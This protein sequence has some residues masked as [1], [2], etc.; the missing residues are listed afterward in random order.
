MTNEEDRT[1]DAAGIMW[2]STATIAIGPEL[3]HYHALE[4][5]IH[6]LLHAIWKAMMAPEHMER[7]LEEAAVQRLSVGI[8]AVLRDNPHLLKWIETMVKKDGRGT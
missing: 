5:L 2:G 6:E 3:E 4:V 1:H 8:S 7:A